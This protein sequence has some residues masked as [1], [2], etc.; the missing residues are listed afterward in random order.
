[1]LSPHVR[2]RPHTEFWSGGYHKHANTD[3]KGVSSHPIRYHGLDSGSHRAPLSLHAH[4]INHVS[5][6]RISAGPDLTHTSLPRVCAYFDSFHS[7]VMPVR[8]CS[9][10][11][12]RSLCTAS[13]SSLPLQCSQAECNV[14]NFMVLEKTRIPFAA[15]H[16]FDIG[17]V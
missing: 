16:E 7:P 6:I 8:R 15:W 11:I 5:R 13:F 4:S 1:M 10:T 17:Y 2:G 14:H 3:A 12:L 9:S